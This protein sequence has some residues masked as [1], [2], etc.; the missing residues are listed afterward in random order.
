MKLGRMEMSCV[1]WEVVKRGGGLKV[2]YLSTES[3]KRVGN[4]A[5]AVSESRMA[6]IG[7]GHV[8]LKGNYSHE[9][10]INI[11][12]SKSELYNHTELSVNCTSSR[13]RRLI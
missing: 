2:L 5:G 10:D 8:K 9:A 11:K 12:R 7:D 13:Y 3:C 1:G 4:E 6:A